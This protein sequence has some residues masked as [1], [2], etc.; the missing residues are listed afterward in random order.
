MSTERDSDQAGVRPATALSR[1]GQYCTGY[2]VDS[3]VYF[4]TVAQ[5]AKMIGVI[6]SASSPQKTE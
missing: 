4:T 5:L 6:L 3:N 2:T 1:G